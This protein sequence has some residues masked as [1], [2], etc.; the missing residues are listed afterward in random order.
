MQREDLVQPQREGTIYSQGQR[1]QKELIQM[2]PWC[3]I[4]SFHNCERVSFY[5]L[6]LQYVVLCCGSSSRLIQHSGSPVKPLIWRGTFLAVMCVNHLENG[7]S[8]LSKAFKWFQPPSL[9]VAQL[10]FQASWNGVKTSSV[11]RSE[12]LTHQNQEIIHDY[13]CIKS[14]FLERFVMWHYITIYQVCCDWHI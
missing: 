9:R 6:S 2:I 5:W 1:P 7:S 11:Y 10:R 12:F 14:L 8:C 4:S 3:W 13:C